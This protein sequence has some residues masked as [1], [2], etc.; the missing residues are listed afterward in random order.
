MQSGAV[1][2]AF[3]RAAGTDQGGLGQY[4]PLPEGRQLHVD[5]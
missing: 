5:K 1:S 4:G 2:Q 3:S